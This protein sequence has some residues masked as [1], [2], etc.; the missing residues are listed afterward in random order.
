MNWRVETH[1]HTLWSGDSLTSPEAILRICRRRNIDR[2]AITDH[3][4]AEG[5]LALKRLAPDLVIVGEEIMTTEGELLAWFVRETVPPGHAP[6][7]TIRRLRD[8]GAVSSVSHPFDRLRRGAW[9][10]EQLE[11]IV[12]HIDAIEVFNA[13]C[14]YQDDNRR[15]RQFAR[16]HGLTGSVG[17]D[18]HYGPEYGRSLQLMRP[19]ADDPQDFLSALRTAD[20]LCRPSSALVHFSSTLAKW[21]KRAGLRKP[22]QSGHVG[23]N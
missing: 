9:R 3:N 21:V 18:A 12:A 4:T 23:R 1:S 22:G 15:A 16:G 11:R 5:A 19:F 6:M 2:I 10:E 8:Q 20:Q 17:S 7:E 14:I 13:R